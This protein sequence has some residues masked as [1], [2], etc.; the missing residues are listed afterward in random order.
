MLHAGR[1]YITYYNG[2]PPMKKLNAGVAT[3][4]F[5]KYR[6]VPNVEGDVLLGRSILGLWP[7]G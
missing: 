7:K 3:D 1:G 5:S 6:A 2:K 4:W